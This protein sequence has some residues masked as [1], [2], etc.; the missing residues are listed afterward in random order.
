MAATLFDELGG[1]PAIKKVHRIFYDKLLS[2]PWLKDF[3]VGVPRPHLE[4]FCCKTPA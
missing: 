4:V 3:F 1:M 2:H